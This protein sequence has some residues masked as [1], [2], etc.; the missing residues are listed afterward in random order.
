MNNSPD[1][2]SKCGG[3]MCEGA[4]IQMS[5]PGLGGLVTHLGMFAHWI[6]GRPEWS[7][8][9]GVKTVGKQNLPIQTFRCTQ[10]GYLESYANSP[11][12]IAE[13]VEPVEQIRCFGAAGENVLVVAPSELAGEIRRQRRFAASRRTRE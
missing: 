3:E 7:F 9:A 5:L 8:W 10:C 6:S 13:A 11:V 4:T 1:K 2:C 12:A